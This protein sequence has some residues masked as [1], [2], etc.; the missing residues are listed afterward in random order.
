MYKKLSVFYEKEFKDF[1]NNELSDKN[2]ILERCKSISNANSLL[3]ATEYICKIDAE[4]EH[5]QEQITNLTQK[6]E[7]YINAFQSSK[8]TENLGEESPLKIVC[9]H[10]KE[11]E[12]TNLKEFLQAEKTVN[13]KNLNARLQ[14]LYDMVDTIDKKNFNFDKLFKERFEL[15]LKFWQL[16]TRDT[17]VEYIITILRDMEAL[18]KLNIFVNG[19]KKEQQLEKTTKMIQTVITWNNR[20][21][22]SNV[23][24]SLKQEVQDLN[25]RNVIRKIKHEND[26]KREI[27][28]QLIDNGL[29]EILS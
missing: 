5:L 26:Q 29:N 17:N 18:L 4:I 9:K 27:L 3:L 8:I 2:Q 7:N 25:E 13:W 24:D 10:F 22:I 14:Y 16:P 6:A 15:V 12:E 21:H 11:Q 28:H 20:A 23:L 1:A 19:E